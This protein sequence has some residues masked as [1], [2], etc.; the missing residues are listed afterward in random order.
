MS[1]FCTTEPIYV[2]SPG[3]LAELQ[4][5][6][7]LHYATELGY[8]LFRTYDHLQQVRFADHV[9]ITCTHSFY[10]VPT[11]ED[12]MFVYDI[13]GDRETKSVSFINAFIQIG[14]WSWLKFEIKRDDLS[15]IADGEEKSVQGKLPVHDE[16]SDQGV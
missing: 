13:Y 1:E 8:D 5:N 3:R 10:S 9:H 7:L 11:N 15:V 2:E 14:G 4:K 16:P 12:I 6:R